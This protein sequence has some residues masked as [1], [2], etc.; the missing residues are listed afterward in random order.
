MREF[1]TNWIDKPIMKTC[2]LPL[3]PIFKIIL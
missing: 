2:D 3:L 1:P